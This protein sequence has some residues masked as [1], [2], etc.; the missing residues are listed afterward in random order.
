MAQCGGKLLYYNYGLLNYC[1]RWCL[2]DGV[3]YG[4]R[5]DYY[6]FMLKSSL[7]NGEYVVAKKYI[8]ILSKTKYYREWA[9]QYEPMVKNPELVKKDKE[10]S[11]IMHLMPPVNELTSD[12]ALVEIFLINHFANHDSDDPAFQEQAMIFALQTKDIGTFW[13]RFF[14]YAKNRQAAGKHMPKHIQE[15]AY[16][17]GHLENKVDISKMPFDKD[18]IDSYNNFMTAA[19]QYKNLSEQEMKPFM[20]DRFGGTFYFEYFFTRDQR[21]Y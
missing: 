2:E 5:V 12:Q 6:K 13:S 19:Q 17:Y 15:A 11:T 4:W 20:Y 14:R 3:E 21:S 9:Q 18:V 7:M 1:Y 8:D 10:F 16:L